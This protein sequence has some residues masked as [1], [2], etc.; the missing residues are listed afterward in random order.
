L[1][2]GAAAGWPGGDARLSIGFES[3]DLGGEMEMD[4]VSGGYGSAVESRWLIV[5]APKC[6]FDF[7][8]DAMADRLHDFGFH[9]IALR[10]DRDLDHYVAA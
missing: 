4:V 2:R 8:V 10:V 1:S 7:F 6:G 9:H 5:P 3:V